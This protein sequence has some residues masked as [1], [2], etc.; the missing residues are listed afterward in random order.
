MDVETPSQ[1]QRQ[2]RGLHRER[3]EYISIGETWMAWTQGGLLHIILVI[4]MIV[5]DVNLSISF[6]GVSGLSS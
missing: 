1:G 3:E 2:I 6:R 5:N 4:P